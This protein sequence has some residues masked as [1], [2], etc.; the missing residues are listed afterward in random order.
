MNWPPSS[1]RYTPFLK[2]D[3]VNKSNKQIDAFNQLRLLIDYKEWN[4]NMQDDLRQYYNFDGLHLN[5]K[6][7]MKLD[8]IIAKHIANN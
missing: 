8:T 6:G 3:I 7:Y 4:N 2:E 1:V 5:Q